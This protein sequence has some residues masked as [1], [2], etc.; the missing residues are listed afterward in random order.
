MMT[1]RE[2]ENWKGK[3]EKGEGHLLMSLPWI[4]AA[5]TKDVSF[6]P[7]GIGS[8]RRSEP[9]NETRRGNARGRRTRAPLR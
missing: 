6:I 1:E 7:P 5:V 3:E 9:G 4:A 2:K 8:E